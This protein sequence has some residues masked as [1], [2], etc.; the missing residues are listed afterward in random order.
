MLIPVV[1]CAQARRFV[2][3]TAD[4]PQVENLRQKAK[5]REF[6]KLSASVGHEHV[7]GSIR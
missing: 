5:P 1:S 2:K 4:D 6:Q 3:R 7:A